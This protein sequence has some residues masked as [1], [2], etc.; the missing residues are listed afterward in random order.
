MTEEDVLK[1]Q[2]LEE[3]YDDFQPKLQALKASLTDLSD[4]YRDYQDL[5]AFYGSDD[6][7]RLHKADTSQIK[8][9]ILSEDQLYDLISDHNDLIMD[10][11]ELT[12]KMYKNV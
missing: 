2:T 11:L 9:G 3:K 6:W 4:H 10:L 7:Y 12:T 8:A 1:V 5:L